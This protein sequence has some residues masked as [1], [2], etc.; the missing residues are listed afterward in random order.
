L[1]SALGVDDLL[2]QGEEGEKMVYASGVQALFTGWIKLMHYPSQ[3]HCLIQY[4]EGRMNG[5][6][7]LW[8]KNGQKR[9][10]GNFKDG[11]RCDPWIGWHENGKEKL[12]GRWQDGKNLSA[13]G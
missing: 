2:M 3:V 7:V 10:E 5:L 8:H 4:K 9:N 1:A 13:M 6:G 12:E 11:K